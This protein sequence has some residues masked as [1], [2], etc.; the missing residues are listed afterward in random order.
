V[1]TPTYLLEIIIYVP[2]SEHSARDEITVTCQSAT[3]NTTQTAGDVIT[4]RVK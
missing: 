3:N 2:A 4:Q 1:I